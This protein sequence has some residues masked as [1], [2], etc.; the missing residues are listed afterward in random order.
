M[1]LY[2]FNW[3]TAV[4]IQSF[5]LSVLHLGMLQHSWSLQAVHCFYYSAF[6]SQHR[7]LHWNTTWHLAKHRHPLILPQSILFR[8][9]EHTTVPSWEESLQ[10]TGEQE[11]T[12]KKTL[13]SRT[14]HMVLNS[15]SC[16]Q[17]SHFWLSDPP[18][19]GSS[20]KPADF[21]T[22]LIPFFASLMHREFMQNHDRRCHKAFSAMLPQS[23]P[24]KPRFQQ[25]KLVYT[26]PKTAVLFNSSM[27]SYEERTK[28]KPCSFLIYGPNQ[29]SP[30]PLKHRHKTGGR[31]R[32]ASY[33]YPVSTCINSFSDSVLCAKS[34]WQQSSGRGEFS[35]Y[36]QVGTPSQRF[37][38]LL[39]S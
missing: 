25:H 23:R 19:Q 28:L 12:G 22:F 21:C 14:E 39:Q 9:S 29:Y 1:I 15:G 2:V 37:K 31:M 30:S 8:Y 17:W 26:L 10:K 7:S 18:F 16:K 36:H 34:I 20:E 32:P 35:E 5:L 4:E 33:C 11:E 13:F 38:L 3:S 24:F 6:S 27:F